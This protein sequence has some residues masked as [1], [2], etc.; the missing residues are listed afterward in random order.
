MGYGQAGFNKTK[1]KT[2]RWSYAQPL[3][4]ASYS[5]VLTTSQSAVLFVGPT[6]QT[7]FGQACEWSEGWFAFKNLA[8]NCRELE[9]E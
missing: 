8:G 9:F 4:E 6:P 2:A 1:G 3:G 7:L 5:S